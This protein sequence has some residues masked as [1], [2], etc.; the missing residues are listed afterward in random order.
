M[1]SPF[2]RS[3]ESHEDFG[4]AT[5]AQFDSGASRRKFLKALAVAGASAILPASG[6]LGQSTAGGS[7]VAPGRI[8]VHHH[9]FPPFYIKA[10]ENELRASGFAPRPW[11]P[12]TSLDMMDKAG[13][14]VAMLSPVQRLVM[15][16]MSDRSERANITPSWFGTIRGDSATLR[17]CLF[18]IR[19]RA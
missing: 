18:R 11:T 12:A 14:A 13:V 8:D 9:L 17:P 7:R 1:R 3:R 15:D 4:K 5:Y 10:M 19:T 6:L 2:C 16:S